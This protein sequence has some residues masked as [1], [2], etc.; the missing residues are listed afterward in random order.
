MRQLA[1][2]TSEATEEIVNV[3]KHN[4]TLAADAVELVNK[5]DERAQTGLAFAEEAGAV[6]DEIQEGARA[7]VDA[8]GQFANHLTK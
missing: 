6:I 7:V 2:R 4:Q 1:S 3:V 5:G 8:V